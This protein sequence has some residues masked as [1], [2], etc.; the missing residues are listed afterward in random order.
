MNEITVIER[1]G[2]NSVQLFFRYDIATPIQVNGVNVVPT[3][4]TGLP[5]IVQ[6]VIDPGEVTALDNGDAAWESVAFTLDTALTPAEIATRARQIYA[7]KKAQYLAL[8]AKRYE[9]SGTRIN[10]VA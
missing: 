3:P 9:Y 7:D 8:Y 4:A 6:A 1:T 5:Q 10:E 2:K